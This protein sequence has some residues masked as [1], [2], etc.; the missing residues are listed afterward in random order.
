MKAWRTTSNWATLSAIAI[1]LVIGPQTSNAGS[2]ENFLQLQQ[3]LSPDTADILENLSMY[4]K[5]WIS[6]AKQRNREQ[7]RGNCVWSECALDDQTDD[8]HMGDYRDGDEK[9]Y[10]YRT[11][12]FCANAAYSLYGIKKQSGSRLAGRCTA[13]HFINSF[14]TYEGADTLLKAL[15]ITPQVYYQDYEYTG[16]GRKRQRERLLGSSYNDTSNA[17]CLQIDYQIEDNQDQDRQRQR[18]RDL[19]GSRDHNQN[20]GYSSSVGCD[21]T[22]QYIVAAFQGDSCD[23]NYFLASIDSIDAYNHQHNSIGCRNIWTGQGDS[24]YTTNSNYHAVYTLLK[25]SWACDPK[26][27][28]NECPDPHGVKGRYEYALRTA[29]QGGNGLMAYK[30]VTLRSPIRAATWALFA[31][32]L[33]VWI[34]TYFVKNQKR[35]AKERHTT[36]GNIAKACVRTVKEDVVNSWKRTTLVTQAKRIRARRKE[37]AK[38][39]TRMHENENSSHCNHNNVEKDNQVQTGSPANDDDTYQILETQYGRGGG[40]EK[41]NKHIQSAAPVDDD[42]DSYQVLETPD[43]RIGV[44]I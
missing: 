42:D 8:A 37:K 18:Q 36:N 7:E 29:A 30:N 24:D 9:W 19:S 43:G 2:N 21:A 40:N 20:N 14:F 17:D 10:Q 28:P 1:V 25:N 39:D 23:G 3:H 35:V 41:K 12:S 4:S 33:C 15:G 11:Q 32:T 26:L 13:S 6:V 22:G 38:M 44:V 31:L 5:L 16:D 27:Y 34:L